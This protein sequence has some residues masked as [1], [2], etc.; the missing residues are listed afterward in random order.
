MNSSRGSMDVKHTNI[1]GTV[2]GTGGSV[3]RNHGG[4]LCGKC[5][6]KQLRCTNRTSSQ[7]KCRI[8]FRV[9]LNAISIC[10]C[11]TGVEEP[12]A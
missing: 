1:I 5:R 10:P 11:S 8:V 6:S 2:P 7:V 12:S 4:G 9:A 3:Y